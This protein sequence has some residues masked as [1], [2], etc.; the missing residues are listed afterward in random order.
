MLSTRRHSI[1]I[2]LIAFVFLLGLTPSF[3]QTFRG[4]INGSVTDATGA[5]VPG[6]EVVAVETATG[7]TRKIVSSSAGDFTFPDL[8]LGSYEVT[9]SAGGFSTVKVERIPVSAGAIYSLPVKLSVASSSEVVEV[10]ASALALDTTTSTQTTTVGVKS[11]ESL[12][13]NGR[14]FTQLL[15]LTPGFSGYSGGVTSGSGSLN[16]MRFEQLNWQ[17]DGV[18][19]NDLWANIPAVNQSGVNGIAGTLLP[20][21]SVEQFSV[22]TQASA[23]AGRNAGG[24]INLALRSGTNALHGT[25]YYFN[26]NEAYAEA[27]PLLAYG[28]KKQENR[29]YNA[30]FSLGGP[31]LRDKLFYF[32]TYEKQVF[33]IGQP[34]EAVE[35]SAAYQAEAKQ[36]LADYNV[37]VNPVSANLLNLLWPS[38][39]LTGQ[40]GGENYNSPNPEFGHSNNGLAK[41][42]Y[43][44]NAKNN[45][46]AHW[47]V[48]QGNQTAPNGSELLYY[49]TI[50]PIHI[51]NYAIVWNFT[52]TSNLTNQVLAGVNAFYQLFIDDKSDF[53]LSGAGFDSGST[54]P[55]VAPH[56]RISGFD[57]VGIV[58]PSGRNDITGHLTDTLSWTKGKH[59]YRFG[60]EYRK[61]QINAFNTGDSSGQFNFTGNQGPW[62]SLSVSDTNILSLADFLAGY[63]DTS[64]LDIGDPKRYV[65]VNTFD[66]FAQDAWRLSSRF[67]LDYGLRFDYEGPVH[68]SS[69]DLSVFRPNLGG[70]VFQGNGINSIYPQVW[71]DVSP[72][73]GFSYQPSASAGTVL[74]GG[75]GLYFDQPVM[76]AF[77]NNKTSNSSPLGI[78]ANPA[79]PNPVFT[80]SKSAY[81]IQYGQQI[82]PTSA[83]ASCIVTPTDVSPCGIFTVSPNFR[84]P[85]VINYN[86]NVEQSLGRRVLAQIGYI[87]NESRKLVATTDINQA[88]TSPNGSPTTVAESYAQQAS[89]PYFSQFPTYGNIN[90]LSTIA[91]GNY[92]SLQALLKFADYHGLTAQANYTWGHALD[93]MS[94][95]RSLLPQNSYDF[96]AEYG[97]SS[98]D[99]RNNFTTFI[100]YALP[101]FSQRM[102]RLSE[103]WMINGLIALHGGQPFTVYNSDDT[104]GTD[105][106]AQRVNLVGNPY[107][108]ITHKF[109]PATPTSSATEQ[110]INPAAF[111]SPPN[112]TFG[113]MRR[114]S[115][116]GPGYSDSDISLLKTTRITERVSLQLRGEVFNAFNRNNFAPPNNTLGGGFGEL[117]S[118]IGNYWG[119]PGVGPGEPRNAQL[120][121]KIVF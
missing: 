27:S 87:G 62:S 103:G 10:S 15:A 14:D 98:L 21:D 53:D 108:G 120:S 109:Y 80:I 95:S 74:R 29:T 60:G 56:I 52:P 97:N 3:A 71:N 99:T 26:R 51:Q 92:S 23:E 19:N 11:V 66:L 32:I 72:R 47:F 86:F 28:E 7:V 121:A 116:Y 90:Q 83:G 67:T 102:K 111:V 73:L 115:L 1:R 30:G 8:P 38:Y 50:G 59:E 25:A 68:D 119:A 81:Q 33:A 93:Q 76:D 44:L 65:Y 34:G 4:A 112:G 46:S 24:V 75:V 69:K 9:V 35:P 79:G 40:A 77:L 85:Y 20:L 96:S 6:A 110:W 78:E 104:T 36:V 105:E 45:I 13:M 113:T 42:D 101:A 118:T 91:N 2:F 107:A 55:G 43:T 58:A 12:P 100:S 49:Y 61:A 48:G 114:N 70:I 5:V 64:T 17:I 88:A 31:I 41:L 117:Y 84:T 18:D 37:P 106:N 63:V 82:F 22:Q 54:Y 39:S 89:R 57:A 94:Q 16:G